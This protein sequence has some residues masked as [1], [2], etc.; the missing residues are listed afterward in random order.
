MNLAAITAAVVLRF[1][2]VAIN[3]R[4]DQKS[5]QEIREE[6]NED[7]LLS[8]GDKSPPYRYVV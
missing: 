6:N 5:E 2:Y 7:E 1:A 4:R 3:K 8:T